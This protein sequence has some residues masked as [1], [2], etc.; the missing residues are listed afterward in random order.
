MLWRGVAQLWYASA[1]KGA[2]NDQKALCSERAIDPRT[3]VAQDACDR[4]NL[5]RVGG[6]QM[7]S[8]YWIIA[9]LGTVACSSELPPVGLL[10]VET[11]PASVAECPFGGDVVSAGLDANV[12][13]VLDDGEVAQRTVACHDPP[14]VPP[15]TVVRLVAEP[16]GAHCAIDGT[17]VQS[18]PDRNGN[19][20][21]DD[22]EVAH[23]AY[24]C[25][26][27]LL[28]RVA[29]APPDDHCVAGG[30]A[31][32]VG[33][34]RN[35]DGRLEDDEVEQREVACGEVASRD[36]AVHDAAEMA[37][38][39]GITVMTGSLTVDGTALGELVLP[40]LVQVYGAIEVKDNAAL[41]RVSLPALQSVDGRLVLAQDPA[42]TAI[43]VPRLRQL[44]GLVL[45]GDPALRD[46]GA[47]AALR[48]VAGDVQITHDDALAELTL[49]IG[50][51][52]GGLTIDGNGALARL[53]ATASRLG[54]VHVGSND[55]LE[56]VEVGG[57]AA[58]RLAQAGAVTIAGNHGLA[59]VAIDADDMAAIRIADSPRLTA[60]TVTGARVAGDV[61]LIGV[62]ELRLAFAAVADAF[63][64]DGR[65]EV[66]GP[67]VGMTS[68]QL[69]VS[70][71]CTIDR[72]FLTAFGPE[73]VSRVDGDLVLRNN[74]RLTAISTIPVGGFIIEGNHALTDL[75]FEFG[76]QMRGTI[77]IA[78]NANLET[79]LF[80]GLKRVI[81]YVTIDGNPALKGFAPSLEEV[82][83]ALVIQRNDGMTDIGLRHL[84]HAGGFAV[85]RCNSLT[86][87]EMPALTLVNV[88]DVT[89]LAN[90]ELRHI[91]FPVLRVADMDVLGNP[92][93][94]ACEVDAMLANIRGRHDQRFNDDTAVCP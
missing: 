78:N 15:A 4:P 30:L 55:Q 63:T 1:V 45:D 57:A 64:I 47:L 58:G 90:A 65:L 19:G 10:V 49:A 35:H 86:E 24:S 53:A 51:I 46:L 50:R 31:F 94:P 66:S 54:A 43:E 44:G 34:D 20:M 16:A 71:T 72:S 38:L 12:N 62:G 48:E 36:L 88:F 9:A 7:K 91:A 17:A 21:L 52:G 92:R 11:T 29:P 37:A 76:E 81:G 70:R 33:R 84:W 42:L 73:Q 5:R 85:A 56:S 61:S 41:V 79:A 80:D 77:T 93:L 3:R 59:R 60:V 83:G 23:V 22:D 2:D 82:T 25:G 28:T 27:A 8:W 87:I 26:E 14:M 32:L 39:A 75:G 89:I 40:R 68:P 74:P 13:G 6:C 69:V 67:M 18:G